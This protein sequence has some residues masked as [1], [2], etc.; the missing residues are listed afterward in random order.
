MA[1]LNVELGARSYPIFI[2]TDEQSVNVSLVPYLKH[3]NVVI[4]SNSTIAGF[5]LE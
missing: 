3:K 5:Y 1:Q 2:N 4:V